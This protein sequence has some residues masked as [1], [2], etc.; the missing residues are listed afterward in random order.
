VKKILVTQRIADNH[1]YVERRDALA[2]DWSALFA[3]YDILP[4]L[5]PNAARDP[6]AYLSLGATGLL[7]TGGDNMGPAG[8]PTVRDATEFRLLEGALAC[9]LPVFGV[10]RGLQ[11]INRHFGGQVATSLPEPH[12]GDHDVTLDNAAVQRVNSFHNQGVVTAGLSPQLTA[13]ARTGG[14]V[15]EALRHRSLP[16][17]AVQWHPERPSPSAALDKTLIEEWLKQCA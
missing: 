7:L 1:T 14:G 17:T 10:C 13:F 5:V 8:E 6:A 2:H 9:K 11:V 4:I 12:V 15:I 3:D 16:V